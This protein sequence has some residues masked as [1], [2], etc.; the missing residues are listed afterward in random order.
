MQIKIDLHEKKTYDE[1]Y[2]GI[3]LYNIY[4]FFLELYMLYKY[5]TKQ[6]FIL[7]YNIKYTFTYLQ[8][9]TI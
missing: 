1:M 7:E 4:C 3:S 9:K 5:I 8:H 6:N 2:C